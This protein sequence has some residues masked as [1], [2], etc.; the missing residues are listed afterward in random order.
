MAVPVYDAY[1]AT[2]INVV[3]LPHI[4][5]K[6]LRPGYGAQLYNGAPEIVKMAVPYKIELSI[7]GPSSRPTIVNVVELYVFDVPLDFPGIGKRT[8]QFAVTTDAELTKR[9]PTSKSY[10]AARSQ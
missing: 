10:G 6:S 1:S 4:Y 5:D 3:D 9:L 8:Y 2:L 7:D